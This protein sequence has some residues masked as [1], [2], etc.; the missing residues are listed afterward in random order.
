MDYGGTK[1][2]DEDHGYLANRYSGFRCRVSLIS[3]QAHPS[4][5]ITARAWVI[6]PWVT[7]TEMASR[8]IGIPS[9]VVAIAW[10]GFSALTDGLLSAILVWHF[11]KARASARW[12]TRKLA[13][14]LISLTL[15]TVLLTHIVGA[16]MCVIFLASPA[17]HRT[18]NNIF[19]FLLEIITELYALS[20][21]FTIIH[22]ETVRSALREYQTE[23]QEN[24]DESGGGPEMSL[25][26]RQ[27]ALDRRVEGRTLGYGDAPGAWT[28]SDGTGGIGY[29][30]SRDDK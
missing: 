5:A 9:Q 10:M 22:H 8:P 23:S 7:E 30:D 21:L 12:S 16:A 24:R 1:R 29:F 4:L 3:Y 13:K 18:K 11:F 20:I 6:N 15:E 17:Q 26:M 2:L 19:W 28:P 25:Q 14:R 27:T